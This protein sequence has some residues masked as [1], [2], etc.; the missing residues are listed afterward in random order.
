MLTESR[1]LLLA[2]LTATLWLHLAQPRSVEELVRA[3][4]QAHGSHPD[5]AAIVV[6]AV[7]ALVEQQPG[8]SRFAG[9][10]EA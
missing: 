8:G 4:E 1:A 7:T 2:D 3:A 5:A 10:I 6:A 9:M